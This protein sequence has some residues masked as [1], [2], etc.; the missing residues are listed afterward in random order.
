MAV[1]TCEGGVNHIVMLLGTLSLSVT[2]R[3]HDCCCAS[4][5]WASEIDY[6]MLAT[7]IL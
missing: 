4:R 1:A 3:V 2:E 6:F 7:D 5:V